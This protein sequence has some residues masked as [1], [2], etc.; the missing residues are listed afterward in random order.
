MVAFTFGQ[1][2]SQHVSL[3]FFALSMIISK[4]PFTN[5]WYWADLAVSFVGEVVCHSIPAS[6]HILDCR[7]SYRPCSLH[8]S[9]TCDM[10]IM[11]IS[12]SLQQQKALCTLYRCKCRI[13]HTTKKHPQSSCRLHKKPQIYCHNNIT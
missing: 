2:D 8:I 5:T 11:H 12:C 6:H 13:L 7:L 10:Y 9:C 3:Y 4:F 1:H